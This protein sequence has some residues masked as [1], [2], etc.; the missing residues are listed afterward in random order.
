MTITAASDNQILKSNI[1]NWQLGCRPCHGL[2]TAER[3]SATDVT[4]YSAASRESLRL[5]V[6]KLDH[7]GPLFDF[8]SVELPVVGRRKCKHG[9]TQVGKAH[10]NL[11][12]DE[13][14]VDF[15]IEPIHDVGGRSLGGCD[16]SYRTGLVARDEIA[17]GR[18]VRQ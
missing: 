7:L 6:R 13:G 4:E 18:E 11:G 14:G 16:A 2:P 3:F 10:L 8:R 17:D 15:P 1:R 5:D 12:I 9:A